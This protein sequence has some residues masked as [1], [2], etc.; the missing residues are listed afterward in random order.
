MKVAFPHMGLVWVGMR[1]MFEE[2]NVDYV[3]PP[4]NSSHT[5]SL[6]MKYA[7]EGLCI[8]FKLTLGNFVEALELGADTLLQAGGAGI[9]RLGRYARTQEGVLRDQGYD[10][11]MITL[12]VSD[13]KFRGLMGLFKSVSGDASWSRIISA[14]RFGIAKFYALDE[15]ERAVQR[16]RAIE[17]VKGT[18]TSVFRQG[19]NAVDEAGSYKALKQAKAEYQEKLATIPIDP[20]AQPLLVGVTGEFYVVLEPFTNLDVEIELGKLGVEVH[21]STFISKWT[22]FSFLNPFHQDENKAIHR[23]AMPYLSRDVGGD[24]WET[25]GEKVYHSSHY[26]GMVHLAPF[27]CLPEIVAQNIMPATREQLPVLTIIC[28]EQ[29]AKPGLI[30]R[31]E[32]FTDLLRY[33][34]GRKASAA[35]R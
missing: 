24:G 13:R 25:V 35:C 11:Q 26:D 9:C 20:E 12:G 30:T 2:L 29:T 21:R 3:I 5:L 32:A 31:L 27:T 17:R 7:P 16:V 8:P 18:A 19:I 6:G 10:F 22:R 15:M 23:A 28:D 34:Q 1:A 14:F 4:L 33:R